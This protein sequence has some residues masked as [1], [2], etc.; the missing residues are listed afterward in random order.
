MKK[1]DRIRN[2]IKN[3]VLSCGIN[4]AITEASEKFDVFIYKDFPHE[5]T[6][7]RVD[8]VD[9]EIFTN[10]TKRHIG[11]ISVNKTLF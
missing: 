4:E 1:I 5:Y 8:F 6:K 9:L 3:R 2:Y 7:I 11:R 10:K